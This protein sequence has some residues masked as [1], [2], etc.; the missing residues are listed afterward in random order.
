M[1]GVIAAIAPNDFEGA[2]H[3]PRRAGDRRRGALHRRDDRRGRRRFEIKARRFVIA[4]GSSP[5]VPPIP[6]LDETPYLT[7]E[8]IFELKRCP[9]HL[10]IIGA[11]PIGLELAQAH[12]RL[13]AK[14]TVLEAAT[15]LAK[16][17]PECA[18]I[19][20]DQLAREGV[21]IRA[22]VKVTRVA[23]RR[24]QDR[25]PS[26]RRR[27]ARRR[28]RAAH[29]LVAAGRRAN[30]D[31]LD[32]EAAGITYEPA[33]IAVDKGLKTSNK[34]V[35]AIGDAA[36]GQFTHAANYHAGIVI[37]NALFRLPAKANDEPDPV[38]DVHRPGACACRPDRG[39]GAR[40][41]QD[42]PRAALALSRERPRAGRARDAR[43]HQGRS[44]RRTASFSA[45]PS[46]ARMRAS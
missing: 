5:A 21:A 22:G 29:L 6:G 17:D 39:A 9:E 16:D 28:S 10:I 27:T 45:Q 13:G 3:R 37:R 25:R 2:L 34:R 38:G 33:G 30:I 15:P 44:R 41:P 43:P 36:G 4:T 26:S 46:S 1:H 7:N 11:G 18:A 35:Y 42:D 19:V 23:R 31:G 40:A 24:R 12:R 20:L 14:V 32:L 8:T